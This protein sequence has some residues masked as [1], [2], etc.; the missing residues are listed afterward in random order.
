VQ[1]PS[2]P[3]N[4]A[5]GANA[6]SAPSVGGISWYRDEPDAAFARARQEKKLVV[7][8]LWAPWCH[9]CL[10]MQAFVLTDAKLP[11]AGARFVFLSLN[12]ELAKNADFIER[13][14]TQG[15]PTFY[16]LAP[17]GRSVRARWLG[18]AS[19]GQFARF[20]ADAER[21]DSAAAAQTPGESE[22]LG[23]LTVAAE[24]AAERRYAEAA[25][26]YR[27]ALDHA[28][29]DW[30]R[31]PDVRVALASALL[32]ANEPGA[33]V[34]LALSAPA[35]DVRAP[36]SVSDF[37]ASTLDCADRLPAN[38]SR[39]RRARERAAS[40]L[41]LLCEQGSAELTPDD[42]ADACGSWMAAGEALGDVAGA[43]RAAE[44][45]LAVLEDAA[46]GMPDT[47]A[48]IY[49][50]ARSETLV[51]LGRGEEALELLRARAAALPD[52]YNPPY[53]AARVALRLKRWELGLE[54]ADRALA[55]AYGPRR[56]NVYGLKADL[57]LGAGRK[58]E[59]VEAVKS[60]VATLSSLPE[61]QKRPEAERSARERL[62][63]L[64]REGQ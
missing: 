50:P 48:L 62:S 60:Q 36:V 31:A 28:P 58:R 56:A 20:L 27:V 37:A 64:E 18:A 22:A 13:F 61:G 35:A 30:V 17:D 51:A 42:R 9:T 14:P 16:V 2:A 43:R 53:Y 5:N 33:C 54:A 11:G 39:Q 1:P 23:L 4:P 12:T 41:A 10:S 59:A 19:P 57:L 45:R 29:S 21:V 46:R 47:V 6:V 26:Q 32:K 3:A 55:L 44:T 63:A 40:E 7:V 34:D 52:N 15:W 8:D 49:D 25:V 38:D 24:L